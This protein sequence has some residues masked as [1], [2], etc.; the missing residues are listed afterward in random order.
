MISIVFSIQ[1]SK[2]E[3]K[4]NILQG[5]RIQSILE[6]MQPPTSHGINNVSLLFSLKWF[7]LTSPRLPDP[8]IPSSSMYIS[9]FKIALLVD[10]ACDVALCNAVLLNVFDFCKQKINDIPNYKWVK[11]YIGILLQYDGR[12]HSYSHFYFSTNGSNWYNPKYILRVQNF[13]KCQK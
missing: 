1:S 2:N 3:R 12:F 7:Q 10:D 9:S 5:H 6:L 13:R 4:I 8:S 11:I